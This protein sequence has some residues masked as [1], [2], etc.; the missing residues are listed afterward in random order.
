MTAATVANASLAFI[1]NIGV[2]EMVV[3]LLVVL[4][5]FG[6]K[7]LP[8]LARGMG[9]GIRHFKDELNGVQ[10]QIARE[11][12]DVTT[13]V[14]RPVETAARPDWA[15]ASEPAAGRASDPSDPA[16]PPGVS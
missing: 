4:L 13:R 1:Q 3:V 8:E 15:E 11:V 14:E 7:K 16:P 6:G 2:P 12:N 10:N 9:R 5:L